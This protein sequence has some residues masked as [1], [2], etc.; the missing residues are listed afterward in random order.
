MS[1]GPWVQLNDVV[2]CLPRLLGF[3][4]GKGSSQSFRYTKPHVRHVSGI[5]SLLSADR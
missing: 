4:E 1:R 3:D 2:P 5:S